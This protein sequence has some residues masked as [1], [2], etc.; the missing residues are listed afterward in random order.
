MGEYF[1]R[2]EAVQN[3]FDAEALIFK[4]NLSQFSAEHKLDSFSKFALFK[5]FSIRNMEMFVQDFIFIDSINA[6]NSWKWVFE[7]V[8]VFFALGNV[9]TKIEVILRK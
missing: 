9:G 5:A 7:K 3:G 2:R 1:C 8:G 4:L 6:V